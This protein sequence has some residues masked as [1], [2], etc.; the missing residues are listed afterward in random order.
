MIPPRTRS[1]KPLINWR[2][3][4]AKSITGIPL[5]AD[6]YL[7]QGRT[8]VSK[9]SGIIDND[10]QGSTFTPR[11]GPFSEWRSLKTDFS[12]IPSMNGGWGTPATSFWMLKVRNFQDKKVDTQ[13]WP[14]PNWWKA[15]TWHW[16]LHWHPHPHLILHPCRPVSSFEDGEYQDHKLN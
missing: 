4:L 9:A 14:T 12:A 8:S 13:P 1:W 5:W 11:R 7:Q 6:S 15:S 16:H 10:R 2:N 3:I